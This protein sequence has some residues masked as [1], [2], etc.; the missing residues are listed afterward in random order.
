MNHPDHNR[1]HG[2]LRRWAVVLVSAALL[3]AAYADVM[4]VEETASTVVVASPSGVAVA[5]QRAVVAPAPVSATAASTSTTSAS[6]LAAAES[7]APESTVAAASARGVNNAP[8][9]LAAG[10]NTFA[11]VAVSADR[12]A[13]NRAGATTNAID[14]AGTLKD[15]T[16]T[17]VV[18]GT[19]S[20]R[21]N[22]FANAL[23]INTVIQNSGANVLIQNSTV[24]NVQLN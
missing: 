20:I 23:G 12:L 1:I 22:S 15:A 16:A 6:L 19:N 24:V 5:A 3:P 11:G 17:N 4:P 7:A 18:T 21:D 10:S 14:I 13:A 9:G 8:G 2:S